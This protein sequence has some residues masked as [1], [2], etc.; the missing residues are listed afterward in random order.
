M[1][2]SPWF[3]SRVISR[4]C[5]GTIPWDTRRPHRRAHI[6]EE[7]KWRTL[8]EHFLPRESFDLK[9]TSELY[10]SNNVFVSFS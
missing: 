4:I 6:R 2:G 7:T 8:G 3:A 5:N 1:A 9:R 10:M